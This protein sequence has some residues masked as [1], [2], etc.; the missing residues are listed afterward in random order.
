MATTTKSK[1]VKKSSAKVVDKNL[2]EAIA[3]VDDGTVDVAASLNEQAQEQAQEQEAKKQ[4]KPAFAFMPPDT[5]ITSVALTSLVSLTKVPVKN[6]RHAIRDLSHDHVEH[7]KLSFL[8]GATFPPLLVVNSTWGYVVIDG[9][10]RREAITQAI[11][12]QGKVSTDVSVTWFNSTNERDILKECFIANKT[13]GLAWSEKNRSRYAIFLLNDA[14]EHGEKLGLRQAA[15][16]VDV[17]PAAISQMLKRDREKQAKLLENLD[18]EEVQEIEASN[19]YEEKD[20]LTPAIKSLFKAIKTVSVNIESVNKLVAA[21]EEYVTSENSGDIHN[22][23][24]ALKQLSEP[25]E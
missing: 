12:E 3:Q 22:I 17:S 10:H 18:A 4:V 6:A 25:T 16:I 20:T 1:A 11:K 23:A 8:D 13:N 19:G 7:L 2:V 14:Q 5:S 15:R 21:F 9:M 24:M